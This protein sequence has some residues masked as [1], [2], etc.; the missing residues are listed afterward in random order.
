M[1]LRNPWIRMKSEQPGMV[2]GSVPGLVWGAFGAVALAVLYVISRYNFLLFHALAELFSIVVAWSLFVLVWNTRRYVDNGALIFV[3]TACLFIGFVDLLHTL[4]YKGMG[5]FGDRFG[6]NLPTQLWIAARY[7]QT[8]ALVMFSILL[9]RQRTRPILILWAWAGITAVLLLLIFYWRVFPDCFVEGVGLTAFKKGSEYLICLVLLVALGLLHR[10]R[11]MLDS[12]VYRLMAGSI[13]VAIAGELAVTFY[14]SVY[15]LSNLIGH[16]FKIV[17]FMLI[18]L[19]LIHSGL[20][21]PYAL[22]FRELE[23]ERTALRKSENLFRKVFDMLPVGL[24][25]SDKNGKVQKG[26]PAGIKIWGAEPLVDQDGYGAFRARRLPSKE[27]IAPHDWA[28]SHTVKEGVTVVDELLEIDAFDGQKKTILNFTAPVLDDKGQIEAAIVVNW[29]VTE[30]KR[31]E[32]AREKLIQELQKAL[33]QVRKLSGMLPIC[34]SCKK[35]RDD[36]GYWQQVEAYITTHSEAEFSHGVCPECAKKL[37]P[38]Y[39]EDMYPKEDGKH[40]KE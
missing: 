18:Y 19:A 15:G 16:Y 30:L 11:G 28:L 23:Q 10:K 36:Q 13:L 27:E 31:T 14:V 5:V 40:D 26:N 32:A 9:G 8:L 20:T 3:G 6:A 22:L 39:Y 1:N 38:E 17:S 21:R 12:V 29:D 7:M 37:Y 25:I 2:D 34:A 33:S 35:I 24:W 4:A